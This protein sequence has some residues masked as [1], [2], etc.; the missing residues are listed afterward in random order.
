MYSQS[1]DIASGFIS[2][3]GMVESVWEYVCSFNANTT[4]FYIRDL[5][6]QVFGIVGW[7]V[8]LEPVQG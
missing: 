2:N 5:S 6:I 8:F 1:I 4:P 3:L 7:G